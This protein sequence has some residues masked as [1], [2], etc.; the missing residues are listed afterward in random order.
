MNTTTRSRSTLS[1]V[2]LLGFATTVGARTS[3]AASAFSGSTA[4]L[5]LSTAGSLSA[6]IDAELIEDAVVKRTIERTVS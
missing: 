4:T 1:R 6:A 5:V 2:A 3:E